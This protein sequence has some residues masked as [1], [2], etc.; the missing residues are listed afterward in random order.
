VYFVKNVRIDRETGN[1]IRTLPTILMALRGEIA[2]NVRSNT[3]VDGV[4]LTTTFPNLP[5]APISRFRLNLKGGRGKGILVVT[6]T[7]RSRIDLCDRRQVT[8]SY[9]N[10]HNGRKHDRRVRIKT[11][12]GKSKRASR[13]AARKGGRQR[14]AR[15][16][17]QRGG[18]RRGGRRST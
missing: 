8:E 7:R 1:A 13:R 3:G 16:A 15:K 18:A 11:P 10:G 12:C 9:M 2:I 6:R 14:P 5:D 4:T 17:H